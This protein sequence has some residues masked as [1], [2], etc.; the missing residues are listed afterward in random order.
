MNGDC[1]CTKCSTIRGLLRVL[2]DNE[3]APEVALQAVRRELQ[4]ALDARVVSTPDVVKAL[5]QTTAIAGAIYERAL[6]AEITVMKDS[7]L[8]KGGTKPA[9]ARTN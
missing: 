5:T 3:V 1:P 9:D 8:M 4:Q 2:R 6:V 7:E